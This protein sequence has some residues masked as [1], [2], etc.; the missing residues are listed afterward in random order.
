MKN[1]PIII[2][3]SDEDQGYIAR[4]PAL[5]YCTA[6]GET[7]EEAARE[8]QDA[9]EGWLTVAKEKGLSIPSPDPSTEDLGLIAKLIKLSY[10]ARA[11][12]IPEQSLFTKIRR[13]T[14]LL[15]SE[16]SAIARVLATAG[17]SF[18]N[19]KQPKKTRRVEPNPIVNHGFPAVKA[20]RRREKV[21]A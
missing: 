9:I 10:I 17:L 21:H 18:V 5:K 7:Y 8:I 13:G 6:F 4:V 14:E 19:L 16:S 20:V 2:E 15:P 3:Y 1:Y 11:A 12:G